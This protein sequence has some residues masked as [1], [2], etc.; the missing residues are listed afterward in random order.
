MTIDPSHSLSARLRLIG[1][2]HDREY[3][4]EN[5]SMLVASGMPIT[6]SLDSIETETRS[7]QMRALVQKMRRDIE[8]GAPLWRA[9]ADAGIFPQH[10]ISLLKIGEES[11]RLAENLRVVSEQQRKDRIFRSRIRSAMMY[12]VFVLSLTVVV[13]VGIAWFILPRLATVFLHLKVK[14]PLITKI[15]IATGTF[16]GTYGGIVVPLIIIAF[17]AFVY[18]LFYYPRTKI[19]GEHILF[20]IPGVNRLIIETELARFGYVFGTLLD[21]G[22]SVTGALVAL[23]EAASFFRFKAFYEHLASS[24]NDGN[25]FQQSFASYTSTHRVLP[26]PV[27]QLIVSGERSGNLSAAL[28]LISKNYEDKSETTTKDV[29]VILEPILLVIVWL[30]VV[31]V[32]LAVILPIYS[33]V[34]GLQTS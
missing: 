5:L 12:P 29:S 32:A 8:S 10:A 2:G 16:L 34:G 6:E 22:L 9:L 30:G 27:Q 13:G 33:L 21:A 11:G 19:A 1:T 14:L 17:S 3:I 28:L 15:L 18:F 20:A 7:K 31:A 24:I 23:A 25:T 26:R 4:V